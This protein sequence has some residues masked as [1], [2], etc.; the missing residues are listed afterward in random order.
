M[1]T[2]RQRRYDYCFT[3][4]LTSVLVH[5]LPMLLVVAPATAQESSNVPLI[6]G[7]VGFLSSTNRGATALQPVLAPVLTVPLGAH[8][9]VESR[10]DLRE[11]LVQDNN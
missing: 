5:L 9:L 4:L 10:A 7:G 11:F 8:L 6:S 3:G 1:W 2:S